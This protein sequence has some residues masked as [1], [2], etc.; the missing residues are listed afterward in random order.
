MAP[1]GV[2]VNDLCPRR[3]RVV[4]IGC[5]K[6]KIGRI[7]MID[8]KSLEEAK[9]W[10]GRSKTLE[11][12]VTPFAASCMAATLD[13][14][15]YEFKNGDDVPFVWYRVGFPEVSPLAACGRD[16]HPALGDFMPP[17]P[18]P[19]R[20]YGGT[21][22]TFHR[23]VKVG[24]PITKTMSIADVVAK[25]G[26]SGDLMFVTVRQ[27]IA[28]K[29]GVAITDDRTQIY[30][31]EAAEGTAQ[32]HKPAQPPEGAQ[33]TKEIDP[34]PVLLFRFS[35]LTMNSHRI[36]YDRKYVTEV[37][38]YPGLVFNGGL[39]MIMLLELFRANKPNA[40]LKQIKVMA[41]SALHDDAPF[42]VNGKEGEEPGTANLWAVNPAGGLAY[43]VDAEY[44]E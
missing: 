5:G 14:E 27:E 9:A 32:N 26:R 44:E 21:T 29:D 4:V 38:G 25:E 6:M 19:R 35:A 16:G 3:K 30:R 11:G 12:V 7:A 39:T 23:P 13:W 42:T 15:D 31:S 28:D 18:L 1:N 33:W 36:H 20:M 43:T 37:E 10:I 22:M 2:S 34:S 41:R 17:S 40:T 8:E 24:E